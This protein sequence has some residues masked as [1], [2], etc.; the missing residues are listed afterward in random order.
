[1]SL[2]LLVVEERHPPAKRS[3]PPGL[4]VLWSS[5]AAVFF[6][7]RNNGE[8]ISRPGRFPDLSLTTAFF[9]LFALFLLSSAAALML[10]LGVLLT[11]LLD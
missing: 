2:R 1:M 8:E 7:G 9:S 4:H 5:Q 11:Y 10:L 6:C 3:F